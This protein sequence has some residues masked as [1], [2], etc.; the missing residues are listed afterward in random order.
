[1][2]MN[3][4][5]TDLEYEAVDLIIGVGLQVK[6]AMV[7]ARKTCSEEKKF[8]AKRRK[9]FPSPSGP[10]AVRRRRGDQGGRKPP[11]SLFV[12]FPFSL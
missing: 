10:T 5:R 8:G 1:M 11:L 7:R 12:F 9:L 2:Q 4:S 3:L 6:K